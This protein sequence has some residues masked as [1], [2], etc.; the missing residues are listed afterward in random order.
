MSDESRRERCAGPGAGVLGVVG[1]GCRTRAAEIV[2]GRVPGGAGSWVGRVCARKQRSSVVGWFS[3]LWVRD[4][5]REPPRSWVVECPV[6][7][8][9]GLAGCVLGSSEFGRRRVL[10]DLSPRCRTRAAE[11]GA[12]GREQG[13][14]GRSLRFAQRLP[15][16]WWVGQVR[17]ASRWGWLR[18]AQ[19]LPPRS[20]WCGESVWGRRGLS[21]VLVVASRRSGAARRRG[22]RASCTRFSVS[23]VRVTG[24]QPP[25][26]VCWLRS[27]V[28]R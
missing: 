1:P 20:G 22:H 26:T 23:W 10:G 2:S 13:F 6:V 4:V 24:W 17:R 14:S 5:G 3:V 16:R 8:D 15:P 25:R 7:L 19:R 9:R 27:Q 18:F 21:E 28:S 12:P 11:I